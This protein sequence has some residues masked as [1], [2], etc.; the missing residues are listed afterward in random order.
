MNPKAA[1]AA[2]VSIVGAGLAGCLAAWS[3]ARAQP[4]LRVSLFEAG[5]RVAGNHTWCFF[6]TD[7]SPEALALLEPL[8]ECR[9]PGYSVYFPNLAREFS[10]PYHAITSARI[11]EQLSNLPNLR[12]HE[13]QEPSEEML[14]SVPLVLDARG[15]SRHLERGAEVDYGYQK[16]V[17]LEVSLHAPH[18]LKQPIVMDARVPQIDGFRFQYVLPMSDTRLLIEDTR[19]SSNS[20]LSEESLKNEV[21]AYAERMGWRVRTVERTERGVLPVP[22]NR[23]YLNWQLSPVESLGPNAVCIG[24]RAGL[25]HPV[26]SYS[27]PLA[28]KV[29]VSLAKISAPSANAAHYAVAPILYRVWRESGFYLLLNRM[30]FRAAV[31]DQRYRVLRRFYQLS[32]AL[33]ANFYAA[34]LTVWNKFRILSGKPPVSFWRALSC[35]AENRGPVDPSHS[36]QRIR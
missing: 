8:V 5:P 4:N 24:T 7:V 18:A 12:L 9:W 20:V 34:Q 3:I 25:Y 21:L 28:A 30:F 35:I 27:L 33:V 19:Y 31:P 1:L 17:G 11:R 32:D 29:A 26:T 10:V 6:A 16:F 22:L 14:R 13:G 15:D 36:Y 2:D 23:K